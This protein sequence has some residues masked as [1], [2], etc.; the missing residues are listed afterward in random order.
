MM[1]SSTGVRVSPDEAAAASERDHRTG[2]LAAR[3]LGRLAAHAPV[4]EGV[5]K[6]DLTLGDWVVVRTKN[7]TY[8]LTAV[9]GGGY[10]V[11][12]GWFEHAAPEEARVDVAGCTWG[13]H[14]ILTGLI[15][16][17]GMFLEFSNGL[18]TTRIRDVRVI[19]GGA[20]EQ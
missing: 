14:A 10:A 8:T 18:S 2:P 12:G 4:L 20:T 17:P 16:A 5:W 9:A 6:R 11:A 3:T 7:S 19:R 15:A 1:E 13:G